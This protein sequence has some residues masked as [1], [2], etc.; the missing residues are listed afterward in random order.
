VYEKWK[1]EPMVGSEII[2]ASTYSNPHNNASYIQSLKNTYPAQLL[3]AYLEGRF[4]NLTSGCVYPEFDRVLNACNTVVEASD[5]LHIGM[6]FN[7][8]KMAAAIHVMRDGLP[9]AVAEI[10]NVLDT[11]AMI[12]MIKRRYPGHSVIVYPDA[13]GGARNTTG[14][15]E[16]DLALLRQAGF[17]VLC[18]SRNPAV[19]DRVISF[20]VMINKDGVRRYKINPDTCPHIV[21]ALE[22]QAYDKN[23]E[24]DKTSGFDHPLD[25]SGY[26]I[27]YRY[28]IQSRGG[29]QSKIRGL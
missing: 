7:I 21:E 2:H 27:Y 24:P 19:R 9:Y 3:E 12:A 14:A 11:P 4:V 10:V 6:D 5:T 29:V 1:K 20:N 17:T 28:P 16:S 13:S 25:A 23:G 8:G 22:K 26:F 18:A 15:A